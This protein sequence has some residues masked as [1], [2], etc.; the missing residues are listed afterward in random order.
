MTGAKSRPAGPVSLHNHVTADTD[1]H[2]SSENRTGD[3]WIQDSAGTPA[4]EMGSTARQKSGPAG[5]FFSEGPATADSLDSTLTAENRIITVTPFGVFMNTACADHHSG[6]V[7]VVELVSGDVD[8]HIYIIS[9]NRT[10][11]ST[12]RDSTVIQSVDRDPHPVSTPGLMTRAGLAA[13]CQFP[14]TMVTQQGLV[15]DPAT[16]HPTLA[17][18]SV[19]GATSDQWDLCGW[20]AFN[21]GGVSDME[22]GGALHFSVHYVCFALSGLHGSALYIQKFSL[23]LCSNLWIPV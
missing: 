7:P 15:V 21:S 17:P 13:S 20:W 19:S 8:T 3:E 6:T 16:G 1:L 4:S 9:E 11:V 10:S 14:R 18:V 5:P 23:W 22:H 2:H 12:D